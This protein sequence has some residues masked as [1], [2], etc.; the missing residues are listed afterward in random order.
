MIYTQFLVSGKVQGVGFRYYTRNAA[1][2]FNIV[3]YARNTSDGKVKIIAGGSDKDI[4][5]FTE[6]I[7][8]GPTF[9]QVSK[10]EIKK[11]ETFRQYKTFKIK[12]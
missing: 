7:R 12:Y 8:Q 2:E 5:Q 11:V 9:S 1:K 3:G 10:L 6:S 4:E